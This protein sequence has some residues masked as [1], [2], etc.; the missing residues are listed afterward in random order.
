MFT[1]RQCQ[2]QCSNLFTCPRS[3][4]WTSTGIVTM[5]T[6]RCSQKRNKFEIKLLIIRTEAMVYVIHFCCL[7]SAIVVSDQQSFVRHQNNHL[8]WVN[9]SNAF[10]KFSTYIIILCAMIINIL[11]WF[12]LLMVHFHLFWFILISNFITNKKSSH[13]GFYSIDSFHSVSVSSHH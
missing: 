13:L 9:V 5:N 3:G 4:R 1:I 2:F 10:I 7:S 11:N 6:L 8:V 12:N